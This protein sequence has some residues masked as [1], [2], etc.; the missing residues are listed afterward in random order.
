MNVFRKVS[1]VMFFCSS[2]NIFAGLEQSSL[3]IKAMSWSWYLTKL[4]IW[5]VCFWVFFLYCLVALVEP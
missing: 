1:R 4:W 3:V 5:G 2:W